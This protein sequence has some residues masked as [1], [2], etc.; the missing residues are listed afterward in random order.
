MSPV[1]N[2]YIVY[3]FFCSS[4]I[5]VR[6]LPYAK[7]YSIKVNIVSN[8]PIRSNKV[9]CWSKIQK[10]VCVNFPILIRELS[11]AILLYPLRFSDKLSSF[12]SIIAVIVWRFEK[13]SHG[14]S[15]FT[16][17]ISIWTKANQHINI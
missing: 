11:L 12:I 1:M 6:T 9:F 15:V 7:V 2:N 16:H 8:C 3:W 5:I 17:I 13:S 10:L 4:D 14:C